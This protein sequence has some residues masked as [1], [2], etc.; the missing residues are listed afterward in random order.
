MKSIRTISEILLHF[1][2]L[3]LRDTEKQIKILTALFK[4]F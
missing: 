2:V 3:S 1:I 4:P